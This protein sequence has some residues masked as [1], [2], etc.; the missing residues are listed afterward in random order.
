MLILKTHLPYEI[1]FIGYVLIERTL[2]STT[3]SCRNG[4]YLCTPVNKSY[5]GKVQGVKN[6]LQLHRELTGWTMWDMLE[7]VYI[8][9]FFEGE[10][11]TLHSSL[12]N[13]DLSKSPSCLSSLVKCYLVWC[14]IKTLTKNKT[15]L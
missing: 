14:L 8:L 3:H 13:R 11:I 5:E 10:E 2:E 9:V 15:I 7:Y 1:R 12:S 6:Y 4:D